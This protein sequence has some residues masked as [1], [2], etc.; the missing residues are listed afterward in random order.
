VSS[1]STQGGATTFGAP[2]M[3][4]V[5]SHPSHPVFFTFP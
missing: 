5:H 1:N 4:I 3:K 2:N